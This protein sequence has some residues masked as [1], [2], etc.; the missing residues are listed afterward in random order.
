MGRKRERL[1]TGG[2]PCE[3]AIGWAD[4]GSVETLALSQACGLGAY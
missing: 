2:L 1:G 3:V 4:W